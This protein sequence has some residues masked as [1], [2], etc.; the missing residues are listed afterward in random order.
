MSIKMNHY[1]HDKKSREQL[2]LK[3]VT[4]QIL[5]TKKNLTTTQ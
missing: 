1:S 3:S 2:I 5:M 4:L